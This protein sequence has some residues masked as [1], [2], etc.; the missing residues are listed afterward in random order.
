MA[1]RVFFSFHFDR[2]SW[3]VGQVRNC[4]AL[5]G[6]DQPPFLDWADWEAVKRKGEQAIQN[7]I[8]NQLKGTSVTVVLV[9]GET[10]TRDWVKYEIQQSRKKG[11]GMFGIILTGMKDRDGSIDYS[12]AKD[13]FQAA[14]IQ[15]GTYPFYH[16]INHN[17]RDN[18]GA[19]V[20]AAAKAA[21][22]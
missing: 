16:W 11:N 8:D 5:L 4:N 18:I 12:E 1:R 3:K 13:V 20:E 10:H 14:G 15:K 2:D 17:G 9:G 7:W 6:Y 21:G 19:W 22:R